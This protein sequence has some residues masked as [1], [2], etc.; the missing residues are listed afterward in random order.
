MKTTNARNN[1]KTVENIAKNA[2]IEIQE[3]TNE[4]HRLASQLSDEQIREMIACYT[5]GV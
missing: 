5:K 3:L 1:E 2:I 4:A